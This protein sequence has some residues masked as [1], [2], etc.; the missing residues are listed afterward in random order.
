MAQVG[1]VG[2]GDLPLFTYFIPSGRAGKGEIE[3]DPCLEGPIAWGSGRAPGRDGQVE[4]S[5][6]LASSTARMSALTTRLLDNTRL[7]PPDILWGVGV[8]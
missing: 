1:P 8:L 3:R 2:P 6:T 7:P 5:I 4:E